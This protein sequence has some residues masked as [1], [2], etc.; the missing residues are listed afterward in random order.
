MIQCQHCGKSNAPESHFCRFCGKQ[1]GTQPQQQSYDY[2]P[3]RPY[4]WQTDEF[5][6]SNEARANKTADHV[7]APIQQQV[8]APLQVNY[9]GPQ[10]M[11]GRYRC[12]NCGTN[13]LPV[14]DRRIST[15]GWITF[16]LLLVFTIVFFWIGLLMK[17]DVPVC[18]ICRGRVS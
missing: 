8:Y 5:R 12:P 18:P 11:T 1:M 13:Y 3:P 7:M 14:I 10:D 15:A 2:T 17:E 4:A 6:T 16:S 9:H